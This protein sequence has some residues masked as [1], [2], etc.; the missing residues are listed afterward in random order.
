MLKLKVFTLILSALL[1]ISIKAYSQNMANGA[2]VL[3]VTGVVA[4]VDVAGCTMNVKTDKGMMEFIIGVESDLLEG[5]HHLASIELEKDDQVIIQYKSN[6]YGRNVIVQLED[7]KQK[8]VV[9]TWFHNINENSGK[10]LDN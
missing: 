9:G 6:P 7:K 4:N 5:S 8:R 10:L 3:T 2:P 1:F